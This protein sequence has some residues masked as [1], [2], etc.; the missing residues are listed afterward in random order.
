M[1]PLFDT[2]SRRGILSRENIL[3]RKFPDLRGVQLAGYSVNGSWTEV[4]AAS[5][6]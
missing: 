5:E 4:A 6:M 1:D 3:T 2:P